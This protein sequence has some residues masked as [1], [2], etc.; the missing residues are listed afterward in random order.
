MADLG[1]EAIRQTVLNAIAQVTVQLDALRA[2][3]TAA[4]TQLAGAQNVLLPLVEQV[5]FLGAAVQSLNARVGA[6]EPVTPPPAPEPTPD[7]VPDPALARAQVAA[8]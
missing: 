7:P 5:T 8:S 3:F 2:D 4:Q 1:H 6:L